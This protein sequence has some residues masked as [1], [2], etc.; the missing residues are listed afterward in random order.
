M[1]AIVRDSTSGQQTFKA[2]VAENSNH[3]PQKI[4]MQIN[5]QLVNALKISPN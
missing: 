1:F 4:G 2:W 5:A 3:L